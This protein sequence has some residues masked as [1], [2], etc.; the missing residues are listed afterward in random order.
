MAENKDVTDHE[1]NPADNGPMSPDAQINVSSPPAAVNAGA[2]TAAPADAA[3]EQSTEAEA[4]AAAA[5][6]AVE[7][8]ASET[9]ARFQE[10][11]AII[12]SCTAPNV[13]S[14]KWGFLGED[15][16][17]RIDMPP[18]ELVAALRQDLTVEALTWLGLNE[19]VD[20]ELRLPSWLDGDAHL[21]AAI[22]EDK[23]T[24]AFSRGNEFLFPM[25]RTALD[26][27]LERIPPDSTQ[28][29]VTLFIVESQDA[30][31]VMRRLGLRAV[32]SEGLEA[33]GRHDV[34]RLFCG[35]E[36]NDFGWRYHFV[37]RGF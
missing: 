20:D 27:A 28:A 12:R 24:V 23:H 33:L 2:P 13:R 17:L 29:P 1:P 6:A 19:G 18:I 5:A 25:T 32:S 35:D 9:R 36:R 4:E 7:R 10:F 15:D 22:D 31:E 11:F 34:Q 16:L 26:Y 21:Y 30:V 3:T 14:E 37:A 8:D